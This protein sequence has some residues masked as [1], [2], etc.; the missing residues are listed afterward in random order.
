VCCRAS[1]ETV[2]GRSTF[3]KE[4]TVQIVELRSK[5]EHREAFPVV[6]ELHGGPDE[7]KYLELLAEMM[8]SGYRMFAARDEGGLAAVT[9]VQVLTNL[10]Y[11]RHLYVYDLVATADARSKGHGAALMGHVERFAREEGCKYVAL[12]CGREREAALR[13]YGRMGFERPGFSMRKALT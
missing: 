10:Y 7:R 6:R 1:H 8:P 13:F 12:A 5:A 11:E 2:L 4:G 9:G 3:G